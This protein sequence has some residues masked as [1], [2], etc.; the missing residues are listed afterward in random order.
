MRFSAI[1]LSDNYD[2][3]KPGPK[4]KTKE[5]MEAAAK[6]YNLHPSE[7]EPY[8]DDDGLGRGDYPKLPD[9][10]VEER[11]PYYPWDSPEHKRNFGEPVRLGD[12][13]DL[14]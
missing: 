6:K 3:F 4:P 10:A 11:D 12:R 5:E 14:C 2:D 1:S 13:P 9:I 8:P 7:Y